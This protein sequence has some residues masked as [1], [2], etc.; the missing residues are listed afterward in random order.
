MEY[1]FPSLN[2]TKMNSRDEFQKQDH[3]SPKPQIEAE[4]SKNH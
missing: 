3:H 4:S 1:N 2:K